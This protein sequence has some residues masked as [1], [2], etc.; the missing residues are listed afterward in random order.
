[1]YNEIIR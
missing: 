1:M